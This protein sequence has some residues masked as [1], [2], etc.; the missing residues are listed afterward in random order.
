MS[1]NAPSVTAGQTPPAMA[2]LT[3]YNPNAVA[4]SVLGVDLVFTDPSGNPIRPS[5]NT[6]VMPI[7]VG[8]TTSAPPLGLI[9]IGPFPLVFNT[10][11]NNNPFFDLPAGS[12][13][14]NPQGALP[15]VVQINVGARVTAS[16][17]SIN[18]AGVAGILVSPTS[19]PPVGFQGGVAQFQ[20]PNNAVLVAAV[21]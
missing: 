12:S 4:V 20:A 15:P 13:P 18:V 21:L 17:G 1:V 8:L 14:T 3:V 10:V 19:Q 2:T 7:G 5:I 11:A 16:D 6:G 9:T